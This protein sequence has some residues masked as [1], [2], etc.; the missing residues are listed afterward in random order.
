M[1][2]EIA[3]IQPPPRQSLPR[4]LHEPFPCPSCWPVAS[5]AAPQFWK[6]LCDPRIWSWA[7]VVQKGCSEQTWSVPFE[8]SLYWSWR[9]YW[10]KEEATHLRKGS[11]VTYSRT[12]SE[13][14]CSVLP[15]VVLSLR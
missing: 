7:L 15:R 2:L 11:F 3:R 6:M 14:V 9:V 10:L 1:A 13:L 12:Q 4:H 8:I 5:I